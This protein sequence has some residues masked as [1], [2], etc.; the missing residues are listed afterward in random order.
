MPGRTGRCPKS[1]GSFTEVAISLVMSPEQMFRSSRYLKTRE[2]GDLLSEVYVP[3]SGSVVLTEKAGSTNSV[4]STTPGTTTNILNSVKKKEKV[5]RC[6]FIQTQIHVVGNE[7]EG[8]ETLQFRARSGNRRET[9]NRG[10]EPDRGA[11]NDLSAA[12]SEKVRR[13]SPALLRKARSSP[14]ERMGCTDESLRNAC[15][16]ITLTSKFGWMKRNTSPRSTQAGP[17]SA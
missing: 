14:L 4:I 16:G 1:L 13:G 12:M 9:T 5:T 17:L 7:M 3:W 10:A 15:G 8:S 2:A 11:T 6:R